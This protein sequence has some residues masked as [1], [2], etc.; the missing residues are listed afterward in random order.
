MGAVRIYVDRHGCFTD[1]FRVQKS[2]KKLL[3][4]VVTG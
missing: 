3:K 4:K 2:L 1:D